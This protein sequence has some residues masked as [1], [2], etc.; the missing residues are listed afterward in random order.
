MAKYQARLLL[1]AVLVIVSLGLLGLNA[2][3][4]LGPVKNVLTP[5]LSIMQRGVAQAW[6]GVSALVHPAPSNSALI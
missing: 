1:V 2:M 4:A 6:G 5:P 3:G